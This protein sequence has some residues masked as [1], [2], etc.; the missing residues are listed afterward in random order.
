M[1]QI[2]VKVKDHLFQNRQVE[3]GA[4][5]RPFALFETSPWLKEPSLCASIFLMRWTARETWLLV[6]VATRPDHFDSPQVA[7]L[8]DVLHP[9][10]HI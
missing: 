9:S 10:A 5:A 7:E 3:L 8:R 4:R 6:I 2:P 1:G